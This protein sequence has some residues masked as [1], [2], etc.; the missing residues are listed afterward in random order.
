M[1]FTSKKLGN[2]KIRA[3]PERRK[4]PPSRR[5]QKQKVSLTQSQSSVSSQTVEQTTVLSSHDKELG[6]TRSFVETRRSTEAKKTSESRTKEFITTFL[7]QEVRPAFSNKI[8]MSMSLSVRMLQSRFRMAKHQE[9]ILEYSEAHALGPGFYIR[10]TPIKLDYY[11]FRG[12]NTLQR[13][14]QT[15]KDIHQL[16]ASPLMQVAED[17]IPEDME[18]AVFKVDRYFKRP[19][20]PTNWTCLV[21]PMTVEELIAIALCR[22][23]AN[24]EGWLNM[25]QVS[26]EEVRTPFP[27]LDIEIAEWVDE[28]CHFGIHGMYPLTL[29]T[30]INQNRD[31]K[32]NEKEKEQPHF[33]VEVTYDLSAWAVEEVGEYAWQPS[34][35][36]CAA[37][38]LQQFY[39]DGK[40]CNIYKKLP[41][42][43]RV[44]SIERYDIYT[45]GLLKQYI[46]Y[47]NAKSAW[48]RSGCGDSFQSIPTNMPERLLQDTLGKIEVRLQSFA[49]HIRPPRS[50]ILDF[51]MS[52]E[53]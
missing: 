16:M 24:K 17:T 35:Y 11:V 7:T 18:R 14:F 39:Q 4:M 43:G 49:H 8:N 38:D 52:D 33:P 15:R 53:S 34:L 42:Q 31:M 47:Q 30:P 32:H 22:I 29:N 10:D 48:R 13:E 6:I 26:D 41:V 3:L 2:E 37:K 46:E 25:E 45:I 27:L 44:R 21:A 19:Y 12:L 40:N 51:V 28:E 20:N 50:D 36:T 1:F 23:V 5:N 9:E